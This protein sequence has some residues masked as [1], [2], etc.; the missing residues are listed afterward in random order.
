MSKELLTIG[1]VATFIGIPKSQVLKHRSKLNLPAPAMIMNA[2]Y[3]KKCEIEAWMKRTDIKTLMRILYRMEYNNRTK[4]E[5]E[6]GKHKSNT[7]HWQS[8]C[9]RF[10]IPLELYVKF[11]TGRLYYEAS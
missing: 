7:L 8:L 3:Y 11:C 2:H 6:S 9:E 1:E 5:K 4:R 10:D